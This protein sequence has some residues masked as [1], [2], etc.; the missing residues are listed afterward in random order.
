MFCPWWNEWELNWLDVTQ[1]SWPVISSR[2]DSVPGVPEV[3]V[4]R[5]EHP[6]LARLRG[7][8]KNQDC[9][10]DDLVRQQDLLWICPPGSTQTGN[11]TKTC[12]TESLPFRTPPLWRHSGLYCSI[13]DQ[14]RLHYQRKHH[15]E[16]LPADSD[17]FRH[18]TEARL[19]PDGQGLLPTLPKIWHLSGTPEESQLQVTVPLEKVP[20]KPPAGLRC[21]VDNRFIPHRPHSGA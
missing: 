10:G 7:L 11:N 14:H 17:V 12:R 20:W 21:C 3:G 6:V 19:Q 2:T 13:P 9:P 4:Q 18:G 8:Q 1:I 16:H 5:G 15:K